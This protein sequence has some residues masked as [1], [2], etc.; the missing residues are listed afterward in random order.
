MHAGGPSGQSLSCT[1]V[2]VATRPG[3]KMGLLGSYQALLSRSTAA[4]G[5]GDPAVAEPLRRAESAAPSIIAWSRKAAYSSLTWILA[6]RQNQRQLPIRMTRDPTAETAIV[7]KPS[8]L[9]RFTSVYKVFTPPRIRRCL[10]CVNSQSA[11]RTRRM[12]S[13]MAAVE[14][15]GWDRRRGSGSDHHTPGRGR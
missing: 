7:R 12:T 6:R 8:V 10:N 14:I 3:R 5:R 15:Q 13:C 2:L 4:R 9:R 1:S 11:D